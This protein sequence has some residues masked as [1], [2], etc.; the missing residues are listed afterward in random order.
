[1]KLALGSQGN[2]RLKFHESLSDNSS[3]Q[4]HALAVAT[5][6]G[7]NRM[8]MQSDLRDVYH[9]VHITGFHP[10]EMKK[11]DGEPYQGV[12]NDFYVQVKFLVKSKKKEVGIFSCKIN[13]SGILRN[14]IEHMK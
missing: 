2:E 12:I 1:M 3:K 5:H 13:K 4:Y 7:I 10:V 11:D 14:H 6:E 9:G 8:V